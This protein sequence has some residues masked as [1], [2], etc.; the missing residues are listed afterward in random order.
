MQGQKLVNIMQQSAKEA[1]SNGADMLFGE[2]ISAKPL[3]IKVDNRFELTQEFLVLTSLVQD[4]ET[5]VTVNWG[6]SNYT[7]THKIED[8]FTSGG[9]AEEDTHSH[10]VTGKKKMTVHMALK[11]GEKVILMRVQGGQKF[12][13][14]DRIR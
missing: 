11:T 10:S 9:T 14:I 13:V 4:F 12:I 1:M 3:K 7:H 6:T 5:E 8:T 2:V